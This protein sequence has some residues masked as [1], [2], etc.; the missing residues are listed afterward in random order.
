MIS[1]F[2][3]NENQKQM[4]RYLKEIC[5]MF[6]ITL[7]AGTVRNPKFSDSKFIFSE[8]TYLVLVP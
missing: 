8:G 7:D 5:E 2:P 4:T 1:V 3:Y 6:L